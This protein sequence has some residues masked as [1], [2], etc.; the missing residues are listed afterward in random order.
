MLR[1]LTRTD[2]IDKQRR[3]YNVTNANLAVVA[4]NRC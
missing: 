4:V 1:P 3:M 2:E